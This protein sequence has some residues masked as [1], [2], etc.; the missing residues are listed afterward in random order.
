MKDLSY[1]DKLS[2]PLD[3]AT[4]TFGD[5]GK[6]GGGKTYGAQRRFELLH[7]AG[8]QC[9]ALDPVG[10]WWSLRVGADGRGTG[11]SVPVFGGAHG[12]IPLETTAGVFVA[13]VV[14]ERGISVILDVSRFRKGERKRF[15]TDFAEEFFHLKKNAPSPVHLFVEESHVFVPQRV[16]KGEERMLGAMEDIVRIGRNYGI[17]TTLISQRAASVNKDVL[18][19][20]ECLSAYQTSSA[21]DRKAI[22]DWLDEN[23]DEGVALLG[24]LKGL[25]QGE[26]LFWSPSWLRCFLKIHITK[27]VTYDGSATPK[28]GGVQTRRA[29]ALAPVDLFKIREAM[30]ATVERQKENNPAMLKATIKAL[31]AR[32]AKGSLAPG[33]VSIMQGDL[34]E[35]RTVA[36]SKPG[37]PE[38][39]LKRVEALVAK[40]DQQRDTLAQTQQAF[41]SEAGNLR[42]MVEQARR[43]LAKPRA[44]GERLSV[45]KEET[46]THPNGDYRKLL[47]VDREALK[48]SERHRDGSRVH[49]VKLKKG[50]Y[51]MLQAL[52]VFG[53]K[54][55][56]RSQLATMV[57]I[58]PMGSTFSSYLSTIRTPGFISEQGDR[59]FISAT[60][61]MHV[62]ADKPA[63]PTTTE[64]LVAM[65]KG[66]LKK[67]GV[68]RMLDMLV[69]EYPNAVS[70]TDLAEQLGI[71]TSGSTLSSYLSILRTNGLM[72]DADAGSV[73]AST[74]LFP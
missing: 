41:V 55:M 54:G 32:L 39:Q 69:A 63:T 67:D 44:V 17:G 72:C 24:E 65:W 9:V 62:G 15:M 43:G 5:L 18:T 59:V 26:A 22:K 23:D 3:A 10:N 33:Y 37:I 45:L 4:Q 27:K 29:L 13:Q 40:M 25:K 48:H 50:A 66:R 56:T 30:Q 60:G 7:E 51:E 12:D 20:V 68:R 11:L 61:F 46:V 42:T 19:Q 38:E 21:Q 8:V 31:Q 52:A 2:L 16:Q 47:T 73:V 74:T 57:G 6:K 70:R 35:L 53:D 1:A 14:V 64:G 49:E 36:L 34:D 58:K 71:G 28:V